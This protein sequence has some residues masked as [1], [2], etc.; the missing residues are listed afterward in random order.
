MNLE[1]ELGNIFLAVAAVIGIAV[2]IYFIGAEYTGFA[3]YGNELFF[4]NNSNYASYDINFSDSEM[5]LISYTSMENITTEQNYNYYIDEAEYDDEDVDEL[6][7]EY[8]AL[9]LAMDQDG[10]R[11]E[12]EL[13]DKKFI[14]NQTIALHI[15]NGSE[16]D[17]YLCRSNGACEY[18]GTNFIGGGYY[19]NP[20]FY[21]I[22]IVNLEYEKKK[23][24]LKSDEDI[25][26]DYIYMIE[27]NISEELTEEAYFKE[28]GSIE[29]ENISIFGDFNYFDANFEL[30]N[31][32]IEFY[33][34]E[35]ETWNSLN[36]GNIT[37]NPEKLKIVLKSDK[38][39]TPV[40]NNFSLSYT[41][42][43]EENWT[44]TSWTGCINDTKTRIC[45]D[46]NLCGTEIN[47]P[48]ETELCNETINQTNSTEIPP[49]ASG[50]GGGG[51]GGGGSSS[52]AAPKQEART[53][54]QKIKETPK[55]QET[56]RVLEQPEDMCN[57]EV[58]DL[59]EDGIDC[60]GSCK[61]CMS[62]TAI[63][64]YTNYLLFVMLVLVIIT[65]LDKGKP[66]ENS[67]S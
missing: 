21:N 20:G 29:T 11:L 53:L 16:S 40:L 35:N 46:D 44:C 31:Q 13:D 26:I 24:Y 38:A 58:K 4:D 8:D 25:D 60:G 7:K 12:F 43:C 9:F 19:S 50:G 49:A 18:N 27:R 55:E 61:K 59:N 66:D 36:A 57:N 48:E 37:F 45:N 64:P 1:K 14:N 28:Q 52:G 51:G 32:T 41:M 62:V 65:L 2:L 42:P 5:K 33:Y 30:N 6:V 39:N 3:A 54:E 23:I 67:D 47:K 34:R 17:I 15:I 22:T 10:E 56:E 63:L